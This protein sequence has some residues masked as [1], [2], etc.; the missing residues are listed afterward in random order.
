[1]KL[2]AITPTTTKRIIKMQN[3]F[4]LFRERRFWPLFVVQFAGAFNDNLMKTAIVVLIAYGFWDVSPLTPGALVALA[5]GLFILPFV[6]FCPLAGDLTD[7]YSKNSIIR[8]VKIVEVAIVLLAIPAFYLESVA[9]AFVVLLGLG[10]HSAFFSP[11]KFAILPQHLQEDELIAANGL[12]STGTFVAILIG[13]LMGALLALAP[14]GL[15]IICGILIMFALLGLTTSF[16]IPSAPPL[17]PDLPITY[18]PLRGIV[19]MLK[20]A[21]SQKTGVLTAILGV[22]WFYF[23]AGGFHAQFPN[24]AKETLGVD[25]IVL[26]IFMV[27][28]SLGIGIGGMMNNRLLQSQIDSKFVPWAMLGIAVFSLD[29]CFAAGNFNPNATE[30]MGLSAFTSEFVGW[31]ILADLF[32]LAFFGGL[33]VVPLRAIVQSRAG[34]KEKARVV[35]SNAMIDALFLLGSSIVAT[36]LL[37][38]G[39]NILDMYYILAIACFGAAAFFYKRG[40]I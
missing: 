14:M 8:A 20:H 6:L 12:I 21:R 9:L 19:K 2:V 1:M 35:A 7:K 4:S 28:F 24:F 5:A 25:T 10:T 11:A 23:V 22:S 13:T 16:L 39:L 34:K 40:R 29:L 3:Q 38:V 27:V 26:T 37:S 36:G 31:R 15:G 30:L 17:N 33:Y 18:N 32:L